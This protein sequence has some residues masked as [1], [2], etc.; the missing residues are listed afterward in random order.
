MTLGK[1]EC[2]V[3]GPTGG[4]TSS[5]YAECIYPTLGKDF[6]LFSRPSNFFHAIIFPLKRCRVHGKT[7]GKGIL[8]LVSF[9]RHSAKEGFAKCFSN[10]TR[11]S[12]VVLKH[13]IYGTAQSK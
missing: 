6:F 10:H 1:D 13:P 5:I 2:H 3:A 11:Q 7:L 8:C 4:L 12:H 9:S